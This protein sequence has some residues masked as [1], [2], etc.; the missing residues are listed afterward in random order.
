MTF[1]EFQAAGLQRKTVVDYSNRDTVCGSGMALAACA[2][3]HYDEIA[4]YCRLVLN[5]AAEAMS[6][7]FQ[8]RMFPSETRCT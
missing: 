3:T 2:M 8:F 4:I 7:N 5:V 1:V 6:G